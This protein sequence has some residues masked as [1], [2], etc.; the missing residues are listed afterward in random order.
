MRNLEASPMIHPSDIHTL[1]EFKRKSTE[2]IERLES[3]RP[4]VLTVEGRPKAI[5]MAVKAFE[6]MAE[7]ADRAEAIEG[8]RRGLEDVDAG[9]TM[10]LE[11][12]EAALRKRLGLGTEE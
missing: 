2:L 5:I 9:R 1:T 11:E 8:I 4:Q 3:G 6:R 10:P 7:L 12:F